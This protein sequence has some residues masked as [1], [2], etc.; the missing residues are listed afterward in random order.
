[1]LEGDDGEAADFLLDAKASLAGVLTPAEIKGLNDSVGKFDFETA[2][3]CL[4]GIAT[5]LSLNLDG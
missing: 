4:S 2:L 5:R 1:M 3:A